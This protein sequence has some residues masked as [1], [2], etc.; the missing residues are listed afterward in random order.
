MEVSISLPEEWFTDSSLTTNG[1]VSVD[2][3]FLNSFQ[4]LKPI[5]TVTLIRQP[6]IRLTEDVVAVLPVGT[7]FHNDLLM[8][9]VYAHVVY[10]VATFSML[11]NVSEGLM[12]ENNSIIIDSKWNYEI[13]QQL[14]TDISVVA[15]LADPSGVTDDPATPE[16]LFTLGIRVGQNAPPG[17]RQN[18][19]CTVMYISHVLN[20]KVQLRNMVTPQ[21]ATIIDYFDSDPFLGE[22]QIEQSRPVA[23]FPYTQQ[24][25]LINTA[26]FTGIEVSVRVQL[27]VIY[28]S[29][30]IVYSTPDNC[31][32]LTDSVSLNTPCNRVI[33]TGSETHGDESAVVSLQYQGLETNVTF[34]VWFPES[35]IQLV[36][37][38]V[39]LSAVEGWMDQE[40][41][42]DSCVQQYQRGKLSAF[43]NFTYS[44][45]SARYEVNI[46][47]LIQSQL[48]SSNDS[49]VRT[50]D[51]GMLVGLQ[52]GECQ[53]S[54]GNSILPLSVHVLASSV[55]V[56][57]LNA[58]LTTG[59][60][61]SLPSGPYE[62]L[63]TVTA[64]AFLLQDFNTDGAKISVIP[65]V[66]F[67][68]GTQYLLTEDVIV[69]SLNQAV[70]RVEES[71]DVTVLGSG[72]TVIQVLWFPECN[73][74][75]LASTNV[76]VT[77]DLPDPS[78]IEIS[79]NATRIT[80]PGSLASQV[81]VTTTASLQAFLVYPDGTR[82]D[83]ST[84]SR[85]QLDLTQANGLITTLV[86]NDGMIIMATGGVGSIGIATVTVSVTGHTVT[87]Q[88]NISVVDYSSLFMYATPYP[89][90]NGS[91]TIT[92]N[93]LHQI[94]NTGIYQQALLQM[95][96]I[97]TDNSTT[98]LIIPP[99]YESRSDSVSVSGNRV[100]GRS[101]GRATITGFFGDQS[102]IIEL[103]VTDT[104]IVITQFI[105]LTLN[106]DTLSGI[107]NIHT[108]QLQ[109]SAVFN[110]STIFN[111]LL[112]NNRALYP[113]LLAF[114]SS[115]P[116][117]ASVS[118]F[119]GVVTLRNNYHELV[120]VTVQT[121][122]STAMEIFRFACNLVADV[123]DID[124]GYQTGIPVPP[125]IIGT[126]F[127]LP[128]YVNTGGQRLRT[129]DLIIYIDLSILQFQSVTPGTDFMP[130]FS[131][132]IN[133]DSKTLSIMGMGVCGS[134]CDTQQL[135][136]IADLNFTA[137]N[138]SLV[139]ISGL[140]MSLTIEGAANPISSNRPFVAGEIDLL[141]TEEGM[142]RRRMSNLN[143]HRIRRQTDCQTSSNCN[144][145]LAGDLN[146]DCI[147]DVSDVQFLLTYLAEET[148]DF[149]LSSFNLTSSQ[150]SELDI[151]KNGVVDLSDAY[152]LE[153]VSLNLLHL[154][155]NVTITPIQLSMDC[156]LLVSASFVSRKSINNS[157]LVFFDFSVPFDRTFTTQQQFDN[158]MF[159]QGRYIASGKS[160]TLQGG[161]VMGG[162]VGPGQYITRIRTD[163]ILSNITLNVL[164]VNQ[165]TGQQ[166]S[167]S[168]SRIQPMFGFPDP[169]FE[170]PQSFEYELP[171]TS[172]VVS[173]PVTYGF[174]P[175]M[176][177]D[178]LLS[179]AACMNRSEII[180]PPVFDSVNYTALVN[181]NQAMGTHVVTV[182]ATTE[183]FYS[184]QY[185][186]VSGNELQY[187][188]IDGTTGNITT[189]SS[190][191][192]ES[193]VTEFTLIVTASLQGPQPTIS[194]NSS[195]IIRVTNVN[196]APV[197]SPIGNVR[198]NVTA[199]V[200]STIVELMI[201]DPDTFDNTFSTL[202]ITSTVPPTS[203]FTIVGNSVV[204][205]EPLAA[206]PTVNYTLQ[207]TVT[208][209][210]N[211]S[212]FSMLPFTITVVNISPPFFDMQ[213]Y[214][215]NVS[216]S[217]E[218]G[219]DLTT[220]NITAPLGS[221]VVYNIQNFSSQ[222]G[223]DERSN[224]LILL[225]NFSFEEQGYY[226]FEIE[227]TVTI[228][229]ENYTASTTIE[230]TVYPDID[231]ETVG[232]TMN[233]YN[234]VIPEGSDNGT[235]VLQVMATIG[236]SSS[237]M[238]AYNL[239]N[240][241]SV[242]F[243][244]NMTTGDIVVEGLLDYE[245]VRSYSFLVMA[246]G[247]EGT[248]D[249][250]SVII[251][252]TDI[253]DNPP[254]IRLSI[255]RYIL[256]SNAPQGS[257][258]AS[259]QSNDTDG[260]DGLQ[261]VLMDNLIASINDTTGVI[262]SSNLT[263]SLAGRFYTLAIVVTDGRFNDTTSLIIL[264]LNPSYSL[265]IHESQ[266][267][268]QSILTLADR[269]V[270]NIMYNSSQLPVGFALNSTTGTLYQIDTLVNSSYQLI[271]N[272]ISPIQVEQVTVN[273]TVIRNNS[274]PT[275]SSGIYQI[276]LPV[277][278]P[279]GTTVV[280]VNA[281][282][283]DLDDQLT[284]SIQSNY[285][286][287]ANIDPLTGTVTT[288]EC[289]PSSME[290][291][292]LT[293][294]VLATD[295]ELNAMALLN[296]SI[297]PPVNT[298]SCSAFN[299]T[300]EV[301]I[302]Y[303]INGGGF[304]VSIDQR[305]T[306]LTYS[307]SFSFL[308]EQSGILTASVGNKQSSIT[309]Q[310]QRLM[311]ATVT[312]IL[313]ND[314]VYYDNPMIKV[315]L[316]VRDVRYSSN[317]LPTTVQIQVTHPNNETVT[318]SC[319]A[320]APDGS[321]ITEALL[322]DHWFN[323]AANISV[324]YSIE[325]NSNTIQYLESV[326]VTPRVNY[327]VN[328]TV[329]LIVPARPLYRGQQFV[330]PIVAH[331]GFAVRSYQLVMTIPVGFMMNDI[332][333]NTSRWSL[334]DPGFARNQDGSVTVSFLA[335]LPLSVAETVTTEMVTA[336]T[337]LA[338]VTLTV[339]NNAVE[340]TEHH[341]N[342]T[343]IELS[344]IFENVLVNDA[345]P[346]ALWI[347]RHG[348]EMQTGTLY[349]TSDSVMGLFAYSSQ[350]ELVYLNNP[351]QYDVHLLT[352][353][354]VGG[355][356]AATPASCVSSN[357]G[358]I[359]VSSDCQSVFVTATQTE[360][361][362]SAN[363]TLH[364]DGYEVILPFKI[365]FPLNYS[366]LV[367]DNILSPINGWLNQEQNCAPV[368]QQSRVRVE[369][370]FTDGETSSEVVDIT[371]RV[372]SILQ[373]QNTSVA[374]YQ[375]GYITGVTPGVTTLVLQNN[376]LILASSNITVTSDPVDIMLLDTTAVISVS[377]TSSPAFVSPYE[378]HS[379]QVSIQDV[380][381]F[382]GV[383]AYIAVTAL[384]SDS[385]RF[386][387]TDVPGLLI[388]SLNTDVVVTGSTPSV[389]QAGRNSGSGE[390]L[391]VNVTSQNCSSEASVFSQT[392]FISVSLPRPVSV[393]IIPSLAQLT[394]PLD[395]AT[396]IGIPALVTVRVV[397]TFEGGRAQD[398]TGDDRTVYNISSGLNITL[399]G[400]V[401]TVRANPDSASGDHIIIVSF[402][403]VNLS[404]SASIQIV[405]ALDIE[406]EAHPFPLYP[407]S[408]QYNTT[409]L[410]PIANTGLWEQAIVSATLLLSD[411]SSRDISTNTHLSISSQPSSLIADI[412]SITSNQV[413]NIN[414]ISAA[415]SVEIMGTFG[416]INS[417]RTLRVNVSTV[418]VVVDSIDNVYL[419]S[420]RNYI[421]GVRDIDSGQ[422]IVSV[423]LND[424]T[425]YVD[426]FRDGVRQ[427]PQLLQFATSNSGVLSVD[428]ST[429]SLT[430]HDNSRMLQTITVTARVLGV[431]NSD[432]RVACNLDPAIGDVDLGNQT[433]LPLS[434][435]SVGSTVD[436]PVYI[437]AGSTGVASLN[438]DVMYPATILRVQDVTL[439]TITSANPFVG[440]INDPPGIVALGGTLDQTIAHETILIATLHFEVIGQAGSIVEFTGNISEFHDIN[441]VLIGEGERFVA[442]NVEADIVSSKRR[443][444]IEYSIPAPPVAMLRRNRRATCEDPPC[445]SCRD[446]RDV[447]DTNFDCVLNVQDVTFTRVYITEAPLG[448]T[449]SLAYLLQDVTDEQRSVLDTDRNGVINTDDA[450]Y[451]LRVVFRLIRYVGNHT[452]IN[453]PPDCGLQINFIL[454]SGGRTV[455]DDSDANKTT[456]GVLVANTN[457][458][459]QQAFD[460]DALID[461]Q[462][463]SLSVSEGLIGGVVMANFTGNGVYT[464]TF[465]R[466][467][468]QYDNIGIS[469]VQVTT[470][471][472]GMS[473]LARQIFLRGRPL[474]PYAYP[475]RLR[476]E[477][478]TLGISQR[479]S[480][481]YNP[482]LFVNNSD[483]CDVSMSLTPTPTSTPISTSSTITSIVTTT[484][485]M[486][487]SSITAENT[488]TVISSSLT[489]TSVPTTVS[490]STDSINTLSTTLAPS[491]PIV[492]TSAV[493]PTTMLISS[494]STITSNS[495]LFLTPSS[496]IASSSSI[497]ASSVSTSSVVITPS[498]S[499]IPSS[500]IAPS[501]VITPPSTIQVNSSTPTSSITETLSSSVLASTTMIQTVS[502][503][504]PTTTTTT[505]TTPVV[506]P[507]VVIEF[508]SITP[509]VVVEGMD[510]KLL[511]Q[512]MGNESSGFTQDY[513][514]LV[515]QSQD[516]TA[517]LA[518]YQSQVTIQEVRK[519]A[520][521][522][523]A[524]V[525]HQDDRVWRDGNTVTVI[526]QV[527]DD[528][529]NTR[530]LL[531][532]TVDMLVTLEN[533][534]STMTYTCRPDDNS[535]MCMINV[536]FPPEWFDVSSIQQTRLTYNTPD[537]TLIATL[538][539][540]PY[541]T[542]SSLN[543]VVVELP[544]QS[545]F[546]S[547]TF[548]AT[549][550][551]YTSF[552]VN[553]F[554]LIFETSSNI[555]ILSVSIDSSVW[556]YDNASSNQR[557]SIAA[558]SNDPEG[559]PLNT[560]RT[561]LL[562][563]NLQ[564]SQQSLA[565]S[566]SFINGTIESL[567][568]TRGAVVLNNLN[569]TSGSIIM[570]TRNTQSTIG[571]IDVVEEHP[572]VLFAV[573]TTSQIV[574]TF[575]LNGVSKTAG[576]T[577]HAGYST[578][579]LREVTSGL[580]CVSNSVS[581][582]SID[583]Q[584]ST[585]SAGSQGAAY[586]NVTI[587]YMNVSID[588]TFKIWFP[589]TPI[590]IILSD[591]TLNQVANGNCNIY[592]KATITVLVDFV[593]GDSTVNRVAVTN[594]VSSSIISMQPS[595]ANITSTVITGVAPGETSI[596]VVRN[597][598]TWGCTN[599]SVS[600]DLTTVYDLTAVFVNNIVVSQ[601]QMVN[602]LL[603]NVG[604]LL[605]IDGD[606][607]G[608]AAAVRYT[609]GTIFVLDDAEFSLQSL[610]TALL[611]TEGANIISRNTG[612]VQLNVTWIPPSCTTAVH[613]LIDISLSLQSPIGIRVTSQ[614]SGTVEITSTSD[615]ARHVGIPTVQ[616]ITVEVL[617]NNDR[618]QDVTTDNRT[619]YM[620]DNNVL[621]VDR[622]NNGVSVTVNDS[623]TVVLGI[624]TV[625]YMSLDPQV[626]FFTVVRAER[627]VISAHHYPPYS[628][629]YSDSITVLRLISRT[630]VRQT[631]ALRLVL[632]L[633]NN[634]NIN[635][636][637]NSLTTF[638]PV[639][640]TPATLLG[641]TTID[642]NGD[643][644][645]S[646]S[647]GE[648]G[649]VIIEGMFSTS[650]A[651]V[652]KTIELT[653]SQTFVTSLTV[654]ALP[655]GT[656]R[657]QYGTNSEP[658]TVN[659]VFDDGSRISNL[660]PSGLPGLLNFTALDSAVFA[661]NELGVLSPLANT[662][663]PVTVLVN[664]V[665]E[666]ISVLYQFF[667]NLDPS[668]GDIDLG[669]L[670]GTPITVSSTSS[671]Q[672]P[673]Y[674]NTGEH[675]L[676]AIQLNVQFDPTILQ[677]TNVSEGTSWQRGISDYN[678]DNVAGS[679][680]FGGAIM[681]A[682]VSGTRIH[683]FTLNFVVTRPV[684]SSVV[685][686]LIG[687]INTITE[688]SVDSNTIG[689]ATP[690]FSRAG[691]VSFII[692]PVVSKRSIHDRQA[693]VMSHKVSKKQTVPCIGNGCPASTPGD[694]NG[695][696]MFDIRDVSFTLI[697]IVEATLGF[698]S[699][700][701]MQINSSITASQRTSL[702]TDLNTIV[703]IAD[704][705]FLLKA[706]FRLVYLI[707]DPTINPGNLSTNCLVE[708][709]VSLTTGT[710]IPVDDVVVYFDI[711]LLDIDTHNNFTESA[712]SDGT[713][714]TYDKGDGHFGGI[715]MAQR[716]STSR[717]VVRINS[718][719][720]NSVIGVSILQ[721]TFDTLNMSRTS[722]T[723]QLF[724]AMTF[725]LIYPNPLD[726]TINIR[727]YNFTVFASH[728]YNPLISS[729]VGSYICT[730]TGPDTAAVVLIT[731]VT[732]SDREYAVIA[733]SLIM[734]VV[735]ILLLLIAIRC[736]CQAKREKQESSMME[737]DFT[738]EDYYVVRNNNI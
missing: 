591:S 600:S 325:G 425:R 171:F 29:G 132:T 19:G 126:S 45:S 628:G 469:L 661:V 273:I 144:C 464:V 179:T 653:S 315:A 215:I 105:E 194:S 66:V 363:I 309:Y 292:V 201:T 352:A 324:Q 412:V 688:L 390:L 545:I 534:G 88:F 141:I 271:I 33:L 196:E 427:L 704:A 203:V 49:V 452:I 660:I 298:T 738:Q 180:P 39:N 620:T 492:G 17:Q 101:P 15:M 259:V 736:T 83:F 305:L 172:G 152:I 187:F 161:V 650:I 155:T 487:T 116:S 594:Y 549:A 108:V 314:I 174:N 715:I 372:T 565:S 535:G 27:L 694:A 311:A 708:I 428:G 562:T 707:Q 392:A 198:I 541:A 652:T 393:S 548:T 659:V 394:K 401:A 277:N 485:A 685:T 563:L 256:L 466:D 40:L 280:Q 114:T 590:Q 22:I 24:S 677:A 120:T 597:G 589:P 574:N 453:E 369:C 433:G 330:I 241:S 564:A 527:R 459:F 322:P 575:V 377:L 458:S 237:T 18:F 134:V 50:S 195:V 607:A 515:A 580:T 170:Y 712:L 635:V 512:A 703:D 55:Q 421:T 216:E 505:T 702:D 581:I 671:L 102:T 579:Q 513:G 124:L 296:I 571:T 528:D 320:N 614:L 31:T 253:N 167:L 189:N 263:E 61:L 12:L 729:E 576:I 596:C 473:N 59:I 429:G 72:T 75:S 384:L 222:F 74:S 477:I 288:T 234:E 388:S 567:T 573:T 96:M 517:S 356:G 705:I 100:T 233:A 724:G 164:Q 349:I 730:I 138:T 734:F 680:D 261:Y 501:S 664:A 518:G 289:L 490:L 441:G 283:V 98:E 488:T 657:G 649:N 334:S 14:P 294:S 613:S 546:P 351:M 404:T 407:N 420:G 137:V 243:N 212:L 160:P 569:S 463:L 520:T 560:D 398:L 123:G 68:D 479:V 186:I 353:R 200:N 327:T 554:T 188:T 583:N 419:L 357:E 636:T 682:G 410:Y 328:Y 530:V 149:Q 526:F 290:G 86:S 723:A 382:E 668:T 651:S 629:S 695:D 710:S 462:R 239:V 135:I 36:S 442:G 272:V 54:A 403:H 336:P 395:A 361:Q 689:E 266:F 701:G 602:R 360:P 92:V 252:V 431:S 727:G 319:I 514:L 8:V 416:S 608:V 529:W 82:V 498:S 276:S 119:T 151:D 643:V 111:E 687:T 281:S 386:P 655:A 338:E 90:Y 644:V 605:E 128:I 383:E 44:K 641:N 342:C 175:F 84:D 81:G 321:C 213:V 735:G 67:S 162:Y 191:D 205:N 225:Q 440:S 719:L 110:D 598:I 232:F 279:I 299:F 142:R 227:A 496:T 414:S 255:Y 25:H 525:L 408:N 467:I 733:V 630:G 185:T 399:V 504:I 413:L 10:S 240:S 2:I 631:A 623:M 284:Y 235:F 93:Q 558:F 339:Q 103:A 300:S 60:S 721:V 457:T 696:G 293:I 285:S 509:T 145:A 332:T 656:L 209:A 511:D 666:G 435:F 690:R 639:S 543:Q 312:A 568:T 30:S 676:G 178:N 484:A 603:I 165:N 348:T 153:R 344:N 456:L 359:S 686:N 326:Q 585:V 41:S 242:P 77:V 578:G 224:Q 104:P 422:V 11:C 522:F 445:S 402:S 572:L 437:N 274:A 122:L 97:L 731:E 378:T 601:H 672:I 455:T 26:Y 380:L 647:S 681:A 599:I 587:T 333:V 536:V 683:I 371:S 95:I 446:G 674:V 633:S 129:F 262:S 350:S 551:A 366:L 28:E 127:N 507:S 150:I 177:F 615:A 706:V 713:I 508:P 648:V 450:F 592:Q 1:N 495:S 438:I 604:Y 532:T 258:I 94:A 465:S 13:R 304:L 684:A 313:L 476:V 670:N 654:N 698:S 396:L 625:S 556:S 166:L 23:I 624:L 397:V 238:I 381:E 646:I 611:E 482:L 400:N 192:A 156:T 265:T 497:T 621:V 364:G 158:S 112:S 71:T 387:L 249:T 355:L 489:P 117:A 207:V 667:V 697:Y 725:P 468:A 173:V 454:Y 678:I 140:I 632:E 711:G 197:I 717:F 448:F 609:D 537:L 483:E 229:G 7:V 202:A 491:S 21:P 230:V 663:M 626:I 76:T 373:V 270:D 722:R 226:Q 547:Q 269:T 555:N 297:I 665:A 524:S 221:T 544:S 436:I 362:Y 510:M 570:W 499:I 346:V 257:I 5:G 714:I 4:S 3:R 637:T 331:A 354:A 493:L 720:V 228:S 606:R 206:G 552:S 481:G 700:R 146:E 538:S 561:I 211:S 423:T 317:V 622:S 470:D 658:L 47:N 260:V 376:D 182:M 70:L 451:L 190:L 502:T 308:T 65:G 679:V 417:S 85:L 389:V 432:L 461:G 523:K 264:L 345:P 176:T 619:A 460:N 323:T 728:G 480:S 250:A 118:E 718:S 370:V 341:I 675:D 471:D 34:R 521:R 516:V 478:D 295:G 347:T 409:A 540:Q 669:N 183:T 584:C 247:L 53:I 42:I 411:N 52:P 159:E 474:A 449:G 130:T 691:N 6:Q 63:S 444:T 87:T 217:T 335:T 79:L 163:L 307:Q 542:V 121:A 115:V 365:W 302:E 673:V 550:Y 136:H 246:I 301:D 418:P 340:N 642:V 406:L 595:I 168:P 287:I 303:S 248:F 193:S 275:F 582:I 291:S 443:R 329:A 58:L 208:D 662:H 219:T 447:G 645:L 424:T 43:A 218:L 73:S 184:I 236:N 577:L 310:P 426:L 306:R 64:S 375:N 9:P 638:R 358:I 286:F 494:V 223:I 486:L 316:Q 204:V 539:L 737:N 519:P 612:Q 35:P 503:I 139:Q 251:N 62:V 143:T 169:P 56:E 91:D 80:P 726:Y 553:G 506:T 147:L 244:I 732:L 131:T 559:S 199:P 181:E 278:A 157:L 627:L 16:I 109:V 20:E 709:S 282:D 557:Y 343:V 367:S 51:D 46:F 472:F 533:D 214:Y 37:S 588:V 616:A 318:G 154:L 385:T 434:S 133:Q 693:T 267:V 692:S 566:N 107:E 699:A 368:Y 254:S 57:S 716:L 148:Y 500:A 69:S 391:E 531:N 125:Q 634:D 593:S 430:L 220:L 617:Y 99:F 379:V 405:Q 268:N 78:H 245:L 415:G 48:V 113:G 618:T 89:I 439:S 38:P 210:L 337:D 640:S 374:V 106:T 475:G 586:A 32:S 610:N 231:N